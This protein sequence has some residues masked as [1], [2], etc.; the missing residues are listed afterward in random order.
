MAFTTRIGEIDV[1]VRKAHNPSL[2][3]FDAGA[4]GKVFGERGVFAFWTAVLKTGPR[5]ARKTWG[6][7]LVVISCGDRFDRMKREQKTAKSEVARK[8]YAE[9]W[10]KHF[11][12]GRNIAYIQPSNWKEIYSWAMTH[13]SDAKFVRWVILNGKYYPGTF[14]KQESLSVVWTPTA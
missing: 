7:S 2:V 5:T 3:W 1:P 8:H 14:A 13:Y 6:R 11:K 12:R 4:R 9:A 10:N